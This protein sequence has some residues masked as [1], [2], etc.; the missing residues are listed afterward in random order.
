MFGVTDEFVEP[1]SV[2]V[3]QDWHIGHEDAVSLLD[4]LRS[5][6]TIP[7]L[8]AAAGWIPTH[9]E[10][11]DAHAFGRKAVYALANIDHPQ[12]REALAH[13]ARENPWPLIS[14]LAQAKLSPTEA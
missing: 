13:I 4:D 1:L 11:D 12:A 6:A 3:V 2:L 14:S 8:K 10:W 9:L 7:A 5:P